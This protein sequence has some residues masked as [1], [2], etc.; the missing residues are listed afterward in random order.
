[1]GFV[2]GLR[3][4]EVIQWLIHYKKRF[5]RVNRGDR[6][7]LRKVFVLGGISYNF[8][9]LSEQNGE[10]NLDDIS[11]IW[12][13]R[14]EIQFQLPNLRFIAK[15]HL[16]E[17]IAKHLE[18]EN[19]ILEDYLQYLLCQIPHIGTQN[20]RGVNKLVVLNEARKLDIETPET[21][22]VTAKNLLQNSIK[23]ITKPISEVFNPTVQN[24]KFATYTEFVSKSSLK[25]NF[26]PSLF[27]TLVEK[28][29]DIRVFIV[30]NKVF[31]MAIRSQEHAQT[32][33]DF[34]KYLSINPNRNFGFK[35]PIELEIKLVKLLHK[36]NLETA[37]IDMIFTKD[38]KFVFLEA[39]PIGQF[40]MTSKPCNYYLEH[41]IALSLIELSK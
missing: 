26:F 14:G 20:L 22:I 25:S 39:N 28:E 36:I 34:R 16:R 4:S 38:G 13:R 27:Q 12:Y 40:G 37:S 10:I 35:L 29:A 8:I 24:R 2:G 31:S 21:Y 23:L 19:K 30:Q 11:A 32:K 33:I 9:L 41:E 15:I 3:T 17:Q 6:L 18:S 1:M 5:V 7:T